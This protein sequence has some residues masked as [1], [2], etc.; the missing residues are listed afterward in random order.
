MKDNWI[1][2][3]G[4]KIGFKS[5][6]LLGVIALAVTLGFGTAVQVVP[7]NMTT[8]SSL[9]ETEIFDPFTLSFD[10]PVTENDENT[11]MLVS[12]ISKRQPPIR[13]PYRPE[14]RSPIRPPLVNR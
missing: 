7:K 5:R 3:K 6:L 11:D 13:I 9:S 2:N 12:G 1:R 10:V 8:E 14:L 4:R